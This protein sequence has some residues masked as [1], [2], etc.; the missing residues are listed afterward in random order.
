[1]GCLY[2]KL[3]L[4]KLKS[5]PLLTNKGPL[6][7][8]SKGPFLLLFNNWNTE[9][10]FYSF[11]SFIYTLCLT[12]PCWFLQNSSHFHCF[13]RIWAI[14]PLPNSSLHL[15]S[16]LTIV[17]CFLYF[18]QT[19]FLQ[20]LQYIQLLSVLWISNT[21]FFQSRTYF[22]S[23]FISLSPFLVNFYS[24]FGSPPKCHFLK[25]TW[26]LYPIQS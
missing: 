2:S 26:G 10:I 5:W 9:I 8:S 11:L 12:K 22:L 6:S 14:L 4:L 18:D 25:G 7:V 16:S 1:M 3:T 20:F 13:G 21:L 19:S 24:S 17:P 15:P 23:T